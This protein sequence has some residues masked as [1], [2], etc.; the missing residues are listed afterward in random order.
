MP[1]TGQIVSVMTRLRPILLAVAGGLVCLG[2]GVAATGLMA[3]APDQAIA[4]SWPAIG[5]GLSLALLTPSGAR[6]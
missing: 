5:A 6:S 1:Q 3:G 4:F 2:I